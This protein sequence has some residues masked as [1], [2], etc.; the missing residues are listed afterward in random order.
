MT[1]NLMNMSYWLSHGRRTFAFRTSPET[2]SSSHHQALGLT[3]AINDHKNP[4]QI[5]HRSSNRLANLSVCILSLSLAWAQEEPVPKRSDLLRLLFLGR[6]LNDGDSL[7]C[8]WSSLIHVSMLSS[9]G[10]YFPLGSLDCSLVS[11][12]WSVFLS[13]LLRTLLYSDW[14]TRINQLR[15]MGAN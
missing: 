15:S 13:S 2:L 6:F 5:F 11:K 7:D 12:S 4:I 8:Q 10:C 14:R 3:K 9:T 1:V